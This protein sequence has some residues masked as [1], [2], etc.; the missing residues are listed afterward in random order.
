MKRSQFWVAVLLVACFLA[1]P[2]VTNAQPPQ[3][4][5]QIF[6]KMYLATGL[7]WEGESAQNTCWN[8]I[9]VDKQGRIWFAGGDHWGT[10]R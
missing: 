9:C 2:A 5:K 4:I 10:D 8:K 1:A 7:D 3:G 6:P